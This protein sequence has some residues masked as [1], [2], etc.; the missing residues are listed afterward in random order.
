MGVALQVEPVRALGDADCL[1]GESF[2][3][4]RLSAPREDP[5]PGLPPGDL[6]GDVIPTR[7][8]FAF[9]G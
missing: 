4:L 2:G 9:D 8:R 7:Q 6:R 3:L 5:S 1:S